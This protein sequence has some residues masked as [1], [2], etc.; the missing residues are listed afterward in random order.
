MPP[1]LQLLVEIIQKDVTKEGRKRP[2]L[3]NTLGCFIEP[4]VYDHTG[5]K[6]LADQTEDALVADFAGDPVHQD[7]VV[8]GYL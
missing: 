6:V 7:V 2:A 4:S 5:P 1:S 3:R 8:Y